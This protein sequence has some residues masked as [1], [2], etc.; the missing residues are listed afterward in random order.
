[1]AHEYMSFDNVVTTLSGSP[2]TTRD[3]APLTSWRR[4]PMNSNSGP[5]TNCQQRRR[6]QRYRLR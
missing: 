1:M 6:G 4:S 2:T 5:T 3:A